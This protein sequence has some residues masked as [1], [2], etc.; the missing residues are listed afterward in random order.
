MAVISGSLV[1]CTPGI[2]RTLP[3]GCRYVEYSGSKGL[4]IY[5]DIYLQGHRDS[6]TQS[7]ASKGTRGASKVGRPV[8]RRVVAGSPGRRIQQAPHAQA[9]RLPLHGM[10]AAQYL[11][12]AAPHL[13]VPHTESMSMI[14]SGPLHIQHPDLRT[15]AGQCCQPRCRLGMHCSLHNNSIVCLGSPSKMNLKVLCSTNIPKSVSFAEHSTAA[16]LTK[17][18]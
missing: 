2:R 6:A 13:Q 11:S 12:P 8:D 5:P 9:G 10:A 17:S 16:P 4:E 18:G 7:G 14:S 3:I 1:K 15:P